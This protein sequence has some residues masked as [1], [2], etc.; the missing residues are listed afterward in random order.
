MSHSPSPQNSIKAIISGIKS[1][2]MSVRNKYKFLTYQNTLGFGLLTFAILGFALSGGLYYTATIPAWACILLSA[3]FASIAHEIEHDLIHQLYFKKSPMVYHLMML[4]VWLIRP[5]TINPW[6]RKT[7]HLNH[8]KTS[9]TPVDIEERLVGNGIKNHLLRIIV[10]CDGLLGLLIFTKEY[11]KDIPNF[12]FWR[13]FNAGFPLTTLYYLIIYSFISFH[14]LRLFD[15]HPHV[16]PEL[17]TSSI[18]VIELAMVIWVAPNLLRA[19]CLNLVTSSMHYY[20]GVNNLLQQTQVL[21]HWLF[22]PFQL[23]CFNFGYTHSI[24]HFVPQ[25]PFYIRQLIS[26]QVLPQ[27]LKLGVRKNDLNSLLNANAYSNK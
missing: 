4:L 9:G 22:S 15:I 12:S 11:K 26:R 23:F 25:Q 21:T 19:I 10:I 16:L 6:Y 27:M 2:D 17:I 24:H 13:V 3:W 8:H 20:G 7:I 1:A 14:A 5:N 18:P